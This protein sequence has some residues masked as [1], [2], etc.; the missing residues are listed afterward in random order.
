MIGRNNWMA[1]RWRASLELR[2]I[3]VGAMVVAAA[4]LALAGCSSLPE[5]GPS[6]KQV[7]SHAQPG[8]GAKYVLVDV[9]YRVTQTIA[10]NPDAPLAALKNDPNT[11]PSD[12]I[13]VGDVLSVSVYQ[14]GLGPPPESLTADH[15]ESGGQTFP[16]LVVDRSGAIVVPFAGQVAVANLTPSEASYAVRRALHGRA[17]DPQVVV[18]TMSSARNSVIVIGEVQK[19]GRIAVGANADHLLDVIALAGGPTKSARDLSVTVVRDGQSATICLAT[20]LD[21]PGQNIRLAPLD[22]V[23]VLPAPRK[24]DVFG[25]VGKSSE[26][27]IADDTLSLAGALARIG[28]LS[29]TLADAHSVLIFRFERPQIAKALSVGQDTPAGVAG[30]PIVYRVDLQDPAGYFLAG[31]FQMAP[32]DL[33][34]VP[35]AKGAEVQKFFTV[36][37]SAIQFAYDAAIIK[38]LFP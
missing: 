35:T 18:S 10:A 7:V 3:V 36:V 14:P 9:D 17:I 4:C 21:D 1:A 8:Q 26:I 28:G 11:V 6:A 30:V 32:N 33:V 20:L 25:S 15:Q 13:G 16:H 27:P 5:D 29:P 19:P 31:K 22:Q 2:P 23:R 24:I 37:N 12:L 34:Y 38:T